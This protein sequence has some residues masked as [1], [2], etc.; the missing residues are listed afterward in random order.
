MTDVNYFLFVIKVNQPEEKVENSAQG[1]KDKDEKGELQLVVDSE[2]K[3]GPTIAK[4]EDVITI[5]PECEVLDLNHARI[6]KIEHLEQMVKLER[7]YLR[8]NL[9]KKIENLDSLTRLVELEL[10]DNQITEIE[11]LD[12]LVNL[13][14]VTSTLTDAQREHAILGKNMLTTFFHW[15]QNIGSQL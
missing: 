8:W 13:E 6:G 4:M 7:L 10:Y 9:L 12:Q 14:W 2:S 15:F 5:D 1:E 3:D 11:N